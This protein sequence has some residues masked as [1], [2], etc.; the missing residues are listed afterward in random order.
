[1]RR[2]VVWM[3]CAAAWM[4]GAPAP[5]QEQAQ[6]QEEIGGAFIDTLNVQAVN[7]EVVVTD[8]RGNRVTGLTAADFRLRVDGKPVS[9]D[10]FAEVRDGRAVA[11]PA[12]PGEGPAALPPALTELGAGD[13]V[14]TNY[15]VFVDEFFSPYKLRNEALKVLAR[16]LHTL[17]PRDRMAVLSFD[18]WRMSVIADWSEPSAALEATLRQVARNKGYLNVTDLSG[19]GDLRPLLARGAFLMADTGLQPG[20]SEADRAEALR[21]QRAIAAAAGALHTLEPPAGRKVALILSGGWKLDPRS[22]TDRFDQAREHTMWTGPE[23]LLRPLTD[24]ANRLGYTVYPVHLAETLLPGAGDR[25]TDTPAAFAIAGISLED[26]ARQSTLVFSAEETGGRL[27]RPGAPHL[28][29]IAADTRSYYWLGFTSTE[30][31]N[32]RRKLKVEVLRDGLKV[33]SRSSFVPIS[34]SVRAAMSVEGALLTGKSVPGSKP[35]S[36]QVGTPE[37]R[38]PLTVAV[39]LALRLP[40]ESITFLPQ[41]GQ[42]LAHL[43][44]WMSAIEPSGGRSEIVVTPA[45]LALAEPPP[46]GKQVVYRTSIVVRK[47]RQ[48]VLLTATDAASGETFSGWIQLG[49]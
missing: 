39:P 28:R 49:V 22:A 25:T 38:G 15:L 8:R 3:L 1:M 48:D 47:G 7:V 36:V 26:A 12:G 23:S 9:L 35:L 6:E 29:R 33:R 4:G 16:D 46:P 31:D 21:A 34:R 43:E 11:P 19:I 45:V 18:G 24:A 2:V 10:Y 17:G 44:I 41:E 32:R 40:V 42:F 37:E 5:A 20:D 13:E 14:G 27:L 30:S